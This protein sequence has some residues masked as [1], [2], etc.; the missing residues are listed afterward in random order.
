MAADVLQCCM[1]CEQPRQFY[2]YLVSDSALD[3]SCSWLS[4]QVTL[5]LPFIRA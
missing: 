4:H 1:L 2:S 5:I 3:L